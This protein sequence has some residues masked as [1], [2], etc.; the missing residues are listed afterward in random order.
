VTPSQGVQ[1][2]DLDSI[3]HDLG[4]L[5]ENLPVA[6]AVNRLDGPGTVLFLNEQFV[7]LFGYTRAEITTVEAWALQAYPDP[8]YRRDV[9][10]HWDAAVGRARLQHGQVESMEFR[11]T[12]KSGSI[13]DV[14]IG[15]AVSGDVLLVTFTD[16]T[17]RRDMEAALRSAMAEL[18]R[19]A[20]ELTENI[21]VG[22]YTMVQPPGGGIGSFSFMSQR[23]LE[24]C[25]LNREEALSD[26]FKAFACVHPDDYEEWVRKNAEV[27]ANKL[28]FIGE[29]RVVV[30]G[31]VRWITA[32]SRPRQLPDGSTVWEGVLTDITPR[33]EAEERLREMAERMQ[34]AAEAAG[35]GFW[36]RDL[37]TERETWD[38]Q[39][40]EIY[41]LERG[42]FCGRWE[43]HVH[44]DDLARVQ[45]ETRRSI[46]QG[47]HGEFL[48]R[49]VRPDGGV[50]HV[51]GL[52]TSIR[53][54]QGRPTHELG[55]NFDITAQ[56]QAE[57]EVAQ[58]REL[59]RQREE[60]HRRD[61]ERKLKTSLTAAASAHEINQ[62][63]ARILLETQ[64]AIERL[65][66]QM[67]G[68]DD[69]QAYLEQMLTESQ[70]V[71]DMIGR[72]KA[73]LRNARSEHQPFHVADVVSGAVLYSRTLILDHGITVHETG[74]DDR[75]QIDGDGPQLKT[76]MVNLIRNAVEA[77][78]AQPAGRR[79]LTIELAHRDGVVEIVV[80]DSGPGMSPE[81]IAALPFETTKPDGTG[82]GLYLVRTCVENHGGSMS[83]GRSP[84]GGAEIRLRLPLNRRTS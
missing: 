79:E 15:A 28:P 70:H 78:A 67:L 17:E 72:M 32:E 64:S 51:K 42:E 19:T 27:F 1:L 48:Y 16:V 40:L 55:V 49:I 21:P 81:H 58:A 12:C 11:V 74:L 35:I 83:V 50:R 7:R 54:S 36:T 6:M 10:K 41:G 47:V 68:A 61:L 69:T 31:Q 4:R 57:A 5:L 73:L 26:P 45:E 75:V 65:H 84:L 39:M 71:V 38:D 59:E 8:A 62:P 46:E 9:F 33:K 14:I 25:G 2:E 24:I 82:L 66:G 29:C 20:Y 30:D 13:R 34:L 56:V 53:D 76:A 23:F 52:S 80:G 18:E 37:T 44:P 3:G 60:A 43:P 63:L 22:T 77:I